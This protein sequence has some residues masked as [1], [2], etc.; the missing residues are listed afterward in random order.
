MREDHRRRGLTLAL[1]VLVAI[2]TVLIAGPLFAKLA[3]RWV[4]VPARR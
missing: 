4:D 1:G 3:A 2:P